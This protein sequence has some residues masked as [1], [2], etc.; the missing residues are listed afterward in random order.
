M[1]EQEADYHKYATGRL[2]L[3]ERATTEFP[4]VRGDKVRYKTLQVF[5]EFLGYDRDGKQIL[6]I[7]RADD[8]SEYRDIIQN[9]EKPGT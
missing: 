9:F 2:Y 6:G 3:P 7:M 4:F 1:S 8:G 5:G